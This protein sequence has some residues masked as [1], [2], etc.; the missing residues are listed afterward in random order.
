MSLKRSLLGIAGAVLLCFGS[1]AASAEVSFAGEKVTIIVPFGEGGA[2]DVY[3]RFF[4]PYLSVNLPGKPTVVVLNKPGGGSIRASNDFQSNGKPD[5][6]TVMAISTSTFNN[7]IFRPD[8]AKYDLTSWT[9]VMLST[10]G[11]VFYTA[12]S[13]TGVKGENIKDDILSLQKA[14]TI[15]G[16]K[17][18]TSAEIRMVLI[19]D[20]LGVKPQVVFG[21]SAGDWKKAV[22]RGEFNVGYGNAT[23][24]AG[25]LEEWEKK[26]NVKKYMSFGITKGGKVVRDTMFPELPTWVEAYEAVHGKAPSGRQFEIARRLNSLAVNSSKA[27]MLPPNTPDEIRDVWVNVFKAAYADPE[28][29]KQ[30]HQKVG[31][32][33]PEFGAEAAQSIKDSILSADDIKWVKE[34]TK[35]KYGS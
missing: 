19:L 7:S 10:L 9:P 26:G 17:D 18:A 35:N 27:F 29:L 11:S 20:M 31:P 24:W 28:F 1:A 12:P 8:K 15:M 6:L 23:T 4:S 33:D 34:F 3:S 21:L 2:T 30:I 22:I 5:G 16:A 25:T 32:Y 13:Q 14:K